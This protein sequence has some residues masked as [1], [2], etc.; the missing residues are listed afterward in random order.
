M[1]DLCHD[2]G[3]VAKIPETKLDTLNPP[4]TF[5]YAYAGNTNVA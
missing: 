1:H 5:L 4:L 3:L 2:F